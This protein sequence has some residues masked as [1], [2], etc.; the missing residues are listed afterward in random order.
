M[1]FYVSTKEIYKY[2]KKSPTNKDSIALV[3]HMNDYIKLLLEELYEYTGDFLK[4]D[5]EPLKEV[6]SE[7]KEI[8]FIKSKFS[9][10]IAKSHGIKQT[11]EKIGKSLDRINDI[12]NSKLNIYREKYLNKK[13]DKIQEQK[14]FSAAEELEGYEYKIRL[15]LAIMNDKTILNS[16]NEAQNSDIIRGQMT[17]EDIMKAKLET[18]KR[19]RES[20]RLDNRRKEMI[21]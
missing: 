19:R 12:L 3:N 9:K 4:L 20:E 6:L 10:T 14:K 7:L 1:F 21:M 5:K 13:L 11:V 15:L 18:E 2:S 17:S 16:L 8:I